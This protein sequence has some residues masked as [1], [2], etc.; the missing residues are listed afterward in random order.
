MSMK[1]LDVVH[2][3]TVSNLGGAIQVS[4]TVT[5]EQDT[6]VTSAKGP[7]QFNFVCNI[8]VYIIFA[9]TSTITDIVI[10]DYAGDERCFLIPAST[11]VTFEV[12]ERSRY[13]VAIA[14]EDGVLRWYEDK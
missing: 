1:N 9:A 13:F 2:A 14:G 7:K 5:D 12:A 10:A 3:P 11:I 4:T 6:G 8:D